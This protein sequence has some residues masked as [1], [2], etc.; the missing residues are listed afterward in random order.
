MTRHMFVFRGISTNLDQLPL[1]HSIRRVQKSSRHQ[2]VRVASKSH[3]IA[4]WTQINHPPHWTEYVYKHTSPNT[5]KLFNCYTAN[6][7]QPAVKPKN[8][9][10]I[11]I[12]LRRR[13]QHIDWKR[14]RE[15]N[16]HA[17]A[18]LPTSTDGEPIDGSHFKRVPKCALQYECMHAQHICTCVYINSSNCIIDRMLEL[19]FPNTRQ[20]RISWC[21][22]LRGRWVSQS[23]VSFAQELINFD[24]HS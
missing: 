7:R 16:T 2:E 20:S 10:T 12:P 18:H 19:P 14:E 5:R 11:P 4:F 15:T 9:R 17:L 3:S 21:A 13:R 23:N 1:V 22:V 6:N 24:Y 8:Y